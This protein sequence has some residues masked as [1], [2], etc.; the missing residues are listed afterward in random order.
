MMVVVIVLT[1]LIDGYIYLYLRRGIG[2]RRLVSRTY[3]IFCC[4]C[5]ILLCVALLMP[6]R[7]ND[8][9][10]LPVMWMLYTY[11]T[12]Y[13][14]KLIFTIISLF[15]FI[16]RLWGSRCLRVFG[17]IGG[18]AAL[19][20]FLT[21][22][23]GAL[24]GRRDI[25]VTECTIESDRLPKSFSGYKIV[26]ISDL[27]VGTWGDDV[28]FIAKLVDRINRLNPDVI[29]FTGDIVNRNTP[30]LL[31]FVG[32]LSRLHAKDGVY[33]VLGNHDYGDYITWESD[34]AH[35]ANNKYLAEL[36]RD[37]G[38]HLLNNTHTFLVR[39]ADSIPLI[40]V[41]NWG[42][43]PF[44]Q[45]GDLDKAYPAD[46]ES[47]YNQNDSLF[48]ILLSHNPEH[49]RRIVREKTNIDLTLAGH[50]HAMQFMLKA[51]KLRWSPAQYKYEQWAGKYVYG[52]SA[53]PRVCYVNIGSGEVGLP[54]R[55]GAT[56]EVTVITLKKR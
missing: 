47:R 41:E 23:W 51:G 37:M 4:L 42:E 52:D 32:E 35:I 15:G 50:T 30:E 46:K 12:I 20:A 43:P 16:P 44:A 36:E 45:Y 27:H 48:K 5:W 3:A 7:S 53:H 38:W 17:I 11:V 26:Q 14:G 1:L 19:L 54:F 31:P 39:G 13:V 18:V 21:L 2:M 9:S 24:W 49:W 25:E 10:I 55:V 34:L 56:P 29:L 33:S 22:W 40:G 8:S 28:S 6:R